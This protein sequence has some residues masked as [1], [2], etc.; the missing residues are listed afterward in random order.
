M[1]KK[2]ILVAALN[3]GLGHATRCIP[4]IRNLQKHDYKPVIASD[5]EAGELLQKEFPH[6]TYIELPSYN[7]QYSTNGKSLKWK[8]MMRTPGIIR[9]I[10]A[11]KKLTERLVDTYDLAGIISDNRW[12]VKSTKFKKNIFITHQLNVLSG[13]TS[14]L[15]SFLHQSYIRK[16]DECWVPDLEGEKNLSGRLGHLEKKP[17]NVKYIGPLSRFKK[18]KA[19]QIYDY[20]VLLSGP[21]PQRSILESILLRE[22]QQT[23]ASILFVRG[24]ISEEVTDINQNPNINIKNY[25]YGSALQEAV[26]CSRLII[27]RPGYTTLMD[28]AR[29]EK[30]AFFIPT[31]GQDEQQYLAQRMKKLKIAPFCQ[32]DDFKLSKLDEIKQYDGLRDLGVHTCFRDLFAFFE[33][34]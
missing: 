14:F 7:I 24:V 23:E 29:L 27:S 8:L 21:E 31:P 22:L 4:I 20:L 30:K 9:T 25:L 2:R 15:S 3:W 12:G 10:K 17:E 18:T 6:L 28:L 32:Q 1:Q 33:G 11:E 5:G 34:E 13:S 19:S 16:F 26:N